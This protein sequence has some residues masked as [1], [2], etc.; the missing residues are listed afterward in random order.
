MVVS[1]E[2]HDT[3]Y[4][5]IQEIAFNLGGEIRRF[6]ARGSDGVQ[7]DSRTRCGFEGESRNVFLVSLAVL[8]GVAQ[9]GDSGIV[10]VS[11]V[12]GYTDYGYY[13]KAKARGV[14]TDELR[15]FI[16]YVQAR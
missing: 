10:R 1:V 2:W 16:G 7:H 5:S 14:P 9:P 11:G 15:Q 3:V 8:E 13:R 4:A 6:E 12:G